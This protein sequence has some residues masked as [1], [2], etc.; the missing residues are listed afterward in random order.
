M[1]LLKEL[2]KRSPNNGLVYWKFLDAYNRGWKK[3][4][5]IS[6]YEKL[7]SISKDIPDAAVFKF[8]QHLDNEDFD[9]VIGIDFSANFINVGVKLKSYDSLIYKVKKEG[10]IFEEKTVSLKSLGLDDIKEKL[11]KESISYICME[12][13]VILIIWNIYM[14]HQIY[15]F[16]KE[17]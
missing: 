11:N 14:T 8:N 4:E 5:V 2:L 17:T 13:K 12:E 3:D 1:R 6:T 16:T 9:E 15:Y 7:A 10:E